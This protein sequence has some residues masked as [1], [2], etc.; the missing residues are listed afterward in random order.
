MK[1]RI[2]CVVFLLYRKFV[3]YIF[4]YRRTPP[5]KPET[6]IIANPLIH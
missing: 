2:R 4:Y 3:I 5:A 6:S 1:E